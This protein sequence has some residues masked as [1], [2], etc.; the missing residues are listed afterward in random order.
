[1][2][3]KSDFISVKDSETNACAKLRKYKDELIQ[4]SNILREYIVQIALCHPN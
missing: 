2:R 1:M 4:F 3:L